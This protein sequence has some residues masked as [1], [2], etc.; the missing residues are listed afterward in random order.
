MT[1]IGAFLNSRLK[2]FLF[3]Q[4]LDLYHFLFQT[5]CRHD[6][7][8]QSPAIELTPS[9]GRSNQRAEW[10]ARFATS[11]TNNALRNY[12]NFWCGIR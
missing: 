1:L 10:F 3:S 4:P 9:S 11:N 8:R 5:Y 2:F 12:A 6:Y 7:K